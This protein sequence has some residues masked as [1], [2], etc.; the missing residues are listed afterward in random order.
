MK[1]VNA[2]GMDDGLYDLKEGLEK[3]FTSLLR[4]HNFSNF[5]I[6][7]ANNN[8]KFKLNDN[9]RITKEGAKY[10]VEK[11]QKDSWKK[12]FSVSDDKINTKDSQLMSQ[13]LQS[14]IKVFDVKSFLGGV[15]DKKI[16]SFLNDNYSEWKDIAKTISQGMYVSLLNTDPEMQNYNDTFDR[17]LKLLSKYAV[18]HKSKKNSY[19]YG[20]DNSFYLDSKGDIIVTNQNYSYKVKEKNGLYTISAVE[21]RTSDED[22][23]NVTFTFDTKREDE[24]KLQ[25]VHFDQPFVL[26]HFMLDLKYAIEGYERDN[27]I[28]EE[29]NPVVKS[30]AYHLAYMNH[31]FDLTKEEIIWRMAF[32]CFPGGADENG[33]YIYD[34]R[35]NLP[36]Q[37]AVEKKMA[38][39]HETISHSEFTIPVDYKNNSIFNKIKNLNEDW[40]LYFKE[41]HELV[42]EFVEKYEAANPEIKEKLSYTKEEELLPE[43]KKFLTISE[44]LGKPVKVKKNQ[45]K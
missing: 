7:A 41:A 23:L 32:Y 37:K 17:E 15:S 21:P 13:L 24:F 22:P 27:D 19:D 33:N 11:L 6:Q 43:L 3:N 12:Y 8:T 34:K 35:D 28:T 25:F 2:R 1:L 18:N 5:I 30:Y 44:R 36:Y 9:Y 42:K 26:T 40:Q 39:I 4:V 10:T 31:N 16:D 45:M 29:I 14:D 38:N 20:S